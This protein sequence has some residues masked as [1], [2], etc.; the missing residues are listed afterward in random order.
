MISSQAINN[1]GNN[2]QRVWH[3]EKD[4]NKNREKDKDKNKNKNIDSDK[5][6]LNCILKQ[7]HTLTILLEEFR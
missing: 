7:I 6:N 3:R 4:K 5:E 1:P 2:Y